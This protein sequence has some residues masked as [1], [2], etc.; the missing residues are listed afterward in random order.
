MMPVGFRTCGPSEMMCMR[1]V[2]G[3]FDES[4][5]P[6]VRRDLLA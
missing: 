5:H 4:K 1:G 6:A 2:S 3:V